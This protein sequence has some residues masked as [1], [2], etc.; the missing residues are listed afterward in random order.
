MRQSTFVFAPLLLLAGCGPASRYVFPD[1]V[2]QAMDESQ[3]HTDDGDASRTPH[4][5]DPPARPVPAVGRVASTVGAR[6]T[7][8]LSPREELERSTRCIVNWG[9]YARRDIT[10]D[11]TIT[12][13]PLNNDEPFTVTEWTTPHTAKGTACDR[14]TITI[15]RSK[16]SYN[17]CLNPTT[18]VPEGI[19][20][21]RVEKDGDVLFQ[22]VDA[23]GARWRFTVDAKTGL[24]K[25]YGWTQPWATARH[26]LSYADFGGRTMLASQRTTLTHLK[27]GVAF[28]RDIWVNEYRYVLV[29]GVVLPEKVISRFS[30]EPQ[31][32]TSDAENAS[33]RVSVYEFS[34]YR[35]RKGFKP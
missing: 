16:R 1:A 19:D 9:Q 31:K 35:F 4:A 24:L 14:D 13:S 28:L 3:R 22:G 11:L 18:I 21:T 17:P 29:E 6:P 2:N 30:F 20:L 33:P 7:G 27:A 32:P 15:P 5:L 10:F 23:R 8:A 12:G 26:V 34:N 25:S